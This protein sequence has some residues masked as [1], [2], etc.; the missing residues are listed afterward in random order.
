MESKWVRDGLVLTENGHVA[1]L[2]VGDLS[3]RLQVEQGQ[4]ELRVRR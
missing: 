2:E 1:I 3:E 4:D